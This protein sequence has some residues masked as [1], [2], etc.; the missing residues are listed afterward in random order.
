MARRAINTA[1]LVDE[2]FPD[3]RLP[4]VALAKRSN[5]GKSSLLNALCGIQPRM[6][7]A[8]VS[9]VEGWTRA[10]SSSRSRV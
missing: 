1:C 3:L 2:E 7:P 9:S 8:S 6:G 4:E 10:S 5:S